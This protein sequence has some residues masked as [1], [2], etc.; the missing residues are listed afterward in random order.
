[1]FE[2]FY[3]VPGNDAPGSGLGLAIV[4]RTA[5]RMGATVRVVPGL[6][7]RGVGFSCTLPLAH[8]PAS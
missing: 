1:M 2:R 6:D 3:R 8:A 7:G 4:Q 5:R